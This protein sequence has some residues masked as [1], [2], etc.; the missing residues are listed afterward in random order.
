MFLYQLNGI[1]ALSI[2][3]KVNGLNLLAFPAT[4]SRGQS[5][6]PFRSAL[7]VFRAGLLLA[8]VSQTA[9]GHGE[10][11]I[12]LYGPCELQLRPMILHR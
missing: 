7:G 9:M 1:S 3:P 4:D 12:Q 11:F 2:D 8:P 10:P 5:Q 6:R